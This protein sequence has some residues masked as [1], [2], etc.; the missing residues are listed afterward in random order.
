MNS[1]DQDLLTT[2]V[3][4]RAGGDVG[5]II[6]ELNALADERDRLDHQRIVLADMLEALVDVPARLIVGPVR[7]PHPRGALLAADPGS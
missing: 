6:S 4:V 3:R 2:T 1:Q 7:E 5:R